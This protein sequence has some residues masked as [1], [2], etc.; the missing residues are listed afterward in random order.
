MTTTIR[1]L[2]LKEEN[3]TQAGELLAGKYGT[4]AE[5]GETRVESVPESVPTIPQ[6]ELQ[7]N[8]ETIRK[9]D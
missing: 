1:Y 6:I 9:V 5:T 4:P 8:T 2:G 7:E 3:L